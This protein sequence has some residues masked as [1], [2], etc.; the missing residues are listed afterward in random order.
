MFE[1]TI[2]PIKSIDILETCAGILVEAYNAE[3]WNDAWTQEIALEKLSIFYHTPQFI[4]W[5]ASING[6]VVGSCVGNIE[7]YFTGNYYYLK[8]MFVKPSFQKRGVGN[9]LMDA[10]KKHLD[11]INVNMIILFTGNQH[12]PFRFYQKSGFSE[13]DGMRMMIL[14]KDENS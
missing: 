11:T 4:G 1:F 7:P 14:N 6:E 10:I 9:L 2:K 3:P 5:T 8:D 13:M 12:F